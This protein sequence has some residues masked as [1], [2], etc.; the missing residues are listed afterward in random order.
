MNFG[1]RIIE[2]FDGSIFKNISQ[3]G[4]GINREIEIFLFR[5]KGDIHK[6]FSQLDS[7]NEK[8]KIHLLNAKNY[9]TDAFKLA[10]KYF[11][12]NKLSYLQVAVSFVKFLA[13]YND[14]KG[15]ARNIANFLTSKSE[16]QDLYNSID[17]RF[18]KEAEIVKAIYKI[19]EELS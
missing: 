19:K 1:T 7:I 9:Y 4:K 3:R 18:W 10:N 13:Y 17:S 8:K 16:I 5:I 15:E 12:I 14:E 2:I 11:P 6:Y